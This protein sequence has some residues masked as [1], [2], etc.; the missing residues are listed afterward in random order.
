MKL[1]LLGHGKLGKE[2]EKIALERGHEIVGVGTSQMIP[3]DLYSVADV[4]IDCTNKEAFEA[5]LPKLLSLKKPLVIATT[6]IEP[7]LPLLREKE[8]WCLYCPNFSLGFAC[9]CHIVRTAAL[10][11]GIFDV[12]GLE[13]HHSEKKD[14]PSGSAKKLQTF[15]AKD[16]PFS[17]VRVGNSFGTHTLI[18][19]GKDDIIT[20]THEAKGREGFARG[21][22]LGAEWI[23]KN[24]GFFTMED[25]F[26]ERVADSF[27]GI[28][29]FSDP[30]L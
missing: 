23:L 21:A 19:E 7:L 10:L 12:A 18:F 1:F 4:C 29:S 20:L 14:A 24:S 8:V 9:F 2:V 5:N 13:I 3:W 11:E 25:F 30:V 27:R 28:D 17:S 15:F 26:H 16:I 22:V 6:G